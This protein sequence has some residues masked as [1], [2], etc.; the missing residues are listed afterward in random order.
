MWGG[1][2]WP[3]GKLAIAVPVLAIP[4]VAGLAVYG[5]YKA[6]DDGVLRRRDRRGYR[7]RNARR[8]ARMT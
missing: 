8:Q 6:V 2:V 3:W 7:R 5:A 1:F 4:V